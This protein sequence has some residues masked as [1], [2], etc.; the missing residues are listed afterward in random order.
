MN[1]TLSIFVNTLLALINKP[2]LKLYFYVSSVFSLSDVRI[3][4]VKKTV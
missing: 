2:R 1:C 3:S 4:P